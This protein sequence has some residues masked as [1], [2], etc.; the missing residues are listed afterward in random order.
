MVLWVMT[1]CSLVVLNVLEEPNFSFHNIILIIVLY[2]FQCVVIDVQSKDWVA[3]VLC[4]HLFI[5][6][7]RVAVESC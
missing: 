5:F 2:L 7:V 6:L 4:V 3:E 1:L